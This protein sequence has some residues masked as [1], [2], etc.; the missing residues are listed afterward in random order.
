MIDLDLDLLNDLFSLFYQD[1]IVIFQ[2]FQSIFLDRM[3]FLTAISQAKV[4][5]KTL[6]G[7][8]KNDRPENGRPLHWLLRSKI[9]GLRPV[10]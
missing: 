4:F 8:I 7:Y 5:L 2:H 9:T 6:V 1:V 10:Q 3:L